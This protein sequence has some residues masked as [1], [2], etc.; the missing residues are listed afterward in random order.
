ME[1]PVFE[2]VTI[3]EYGLF[4]G[5][6]DKNLLDLSLT[7]GPW[8]VLGVNGQGKSTFLL[9]LKHALTGASRLREAGFTGERS[10]LTTPYQ[11]LFAVRVGDAARDA[12]II[13]KARFGSSVLEVERRLSD[14]GLEVATLTSASDSR[15]VS[16]EEDYRILLTEA[17]GL[18][19]IEDAFRVLD[20]VTF[21]LEDRAPLIWDVSAQFELFRAILTPDLSH[22]L[23]R[24]EGEIVSN[25][26]A[27]RNLNA[28]LYKLT[29][30]QRQDLSKLTESAEIIARLSKVNAELDSLDSSE[31]KLLDKKEQWDE[32]R[33]DA[34]IV[35]K[36]AE[37]DADE[38]ARAYESLKF[39]VLRHAF[40]GVTPNEQYMFLK[41][42]AERAC[43]SCGKSA[44]E[45]AIELER[46][47]DKNACLVCGSPRPKTR[48]VVTTTAAMQTKV[49]KSFVKLQEARQKRE[50]AGSNFEEVLVGYSNIVKELDQTR[51][52]I[53]AVEREI[54]KLQKRLPASDRAVLSRQESRIIILREAVIEFRRKRDQAE[55]EI[56]ELLKILRTKTEDIK[57]QVEIIYVKRAKE[58]FAEDVRLVYASRTERIGQ[59]GRNFQFPA[60][61]VEMTN[62]ATGG[63]FIRRTADQVSHSQREYLDIVFRKTLIEIF[64]SGSSSLVIDGPEVALDAVFADLAGNLFSQFS[65]PNSSAN[66][67]LA[68][69]VIEGG[70]IPNTLRKYRGYNGR[71]K[72]LIN[73]LELGVS[74][75]ALEALNSKY[76]N[77][78]ESILQ[79]KPR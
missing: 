71:K 4:P 32:H 34:R 59:A 48:K 7:P 63:Q 37:Y 22:D 58:F 31:I 60:F 75:A 8:I 1:F 76:I 51:H 3:R 27:A 6:D 52:E 41:L 14:L 65:A 30:K 15:E 9:L 36:R 57:E 29:Q 54:R 49:E 66:V 61:E 13:V 20:R 68:C 19:G 73:L 77:K 12:K 28:T 72:R 33:S 44:E 39:D 55:D 45:T 2:Q 50:K 5:K 35:L 24:L 23:R 43:P 40:A 64:G 21:C 11:R 25:D 10:D 18:A 46:R 26:S 78:V 38:A 56:E 16:D 70:F 69:N 53:D 47:R 42:I 67:I 79:Q 74:T 62:S 17:M